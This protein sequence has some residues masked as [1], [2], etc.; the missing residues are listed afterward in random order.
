MTFDAVVAA[1]LDWGIGKD[2]GLP[3][4]RLKG[5]MAHFR[6]VTSASEA[7]KLNAIIMGRK[8]WESKEMRGQPL[9]NRLNIVLTRRGMTVPDG[10]VVAGS[11]DAALTAARA[12][13]IDRVFVLGGAEIFRESFVH[14]ELG[15]VYL[16]RVE[17]R[18]GCDVSIP[19][20]D[21][22]GFVKMPWE[23]EQELED[24]GVRYRIEKLVR[25]AAG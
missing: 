20:L 23:G 19:D 18:Y 17:A 21:A 16:T 1:D 25:A 22:A 3:W 15:V 7:G 4:P 10:V 5:D 6:R 11:L 8:T 2:S 13:T 12:P 24:N 9:P 14:A